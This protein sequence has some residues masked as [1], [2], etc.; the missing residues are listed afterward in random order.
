MSGLVA[1]VVVVA[2][3]ESSPAHRIHRVIVFAD[4][5]QAM[6]YPL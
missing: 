1:M 6:V 2:A 4:M 3:A 5:F